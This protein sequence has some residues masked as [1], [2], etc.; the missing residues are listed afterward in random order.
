L[1][2]QTSRHT[3]LRRQAVQK[4]LGS[5]LSKG[6]ASQTTGEEELAKEGT[7]STKVY[8]PTIVSSTQLHQSLIS[9]QENTRD[10]TPCKISSVSN[11]NYKNMGAT[12]NSDGNWLSRGTY[13]TRKRSAKERG[14]IYINGSYLI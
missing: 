9:N 13:H 5:G 2:G 3:S 8:E 6:I 4:G 12:T 11:K 7:D 14:Q 10:I 1:Q